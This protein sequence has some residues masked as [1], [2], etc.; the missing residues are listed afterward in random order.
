M[1]DTYPYVI[2]NNR[3]PAFLEKV[4]VAAK[5]TKYTVELLK[6]MGFVSSNDRAI[7][8]LMKKLGFLNEAGVPTEHYDRLKD[9]SDHPYAIG[10]RIRELYADIFALN[11]EMQKAPEDDVR[12]AFARTT[13]KDHDTVTRYFNTF[14]AL[15]ALAKF[16][17]PTPEPKK[18]TITEPE[19]KRE[20]GPVSPLRL[21][22][23]FHHNI[24]IHLPATT[25][26][27]VY[28]AIFK[29]LRDHLQE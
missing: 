2:S 19:K 3:L 15:V 18:Q 29:S 25:D 6:Q 7:L 17:G 27:G 26:V 28:N 11:T 20:D 14:K 12:G 8:P 24:Q 22:G 21:D 5:P 9:P 1:A 13:G 16:N 23:G 4:K 10:D